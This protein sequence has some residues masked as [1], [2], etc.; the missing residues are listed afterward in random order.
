LAGLEV[1][2]ALRATEAPAL[3]GTALP[4]ELLRRASG[5]PPSSLAHEFMTADWSP[6][7]HADV[8][9]AMAEAKLDWVGS[10]GLPENFPSLML[11]RTQRAVHDRFDDPLMRELVKDACSGRLLRQDVFVRGPTRLTATA[12]DAALRAL[13]LAPLL[14]PEDAAFE[15]D[16]PAGTAVLDRDFYGTVMAGLALGKRPVGAL[17]ALA[18]GSDNP[19]EMVALLVGAGQALV[20]GPDASPAPESAHRFNAAAARRLVRPETLGHGAALAAPAWGTGLPVPVIDLFL[21]ERIEAAGG[22]IAP[23]LLAAS[24]DPDPA[25]HAGI[26]GLLAAALERRLALWRAAGAL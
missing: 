4:G 21:A 5:Q 11:T 14:R 26:T 12:R 3:A 9:A 6:C 15:L 23:A 20:A 1:A 19:A 13:W 17:V 8:A 25:A 10:A 18:G 2:Q 16:T 24:L 22:V 7:F